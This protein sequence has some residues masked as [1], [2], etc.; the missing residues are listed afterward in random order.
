MKIPHQQIDASLSW[1]WS[2]SGLASCVACLLVALATIG[3]ADHARAD[4]NDGG[5]DPGVASGG[6]ETVGTLPILGGVRI[7][8]P[9]VR[10]WRGDRPAFYL[11]GTAAELG[12][13][14][15]GARGRGFATVEVLDPQSGRVRIAFHGDVTVILDRE[16]TGVL[17]VQTGLA[18]PEGFGPRR[19]TLEWGSSATRTVRLHA[20][21]L[22][23]AVGSMS[24]NGL[25][26]QAPL[27]VRV[28]G[29]GGT[30]HSDAVFATPGTLILRQSY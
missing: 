17:A 11:E 22:P 2:R 21:L 18:V 29:Q 19:A 26:D 7:E 16:L 8:L 23:L 5:G 30:V 9:L 28:S 25:L 20:G 1:G 27:K 4:I 24:A 15:R 12:Y 3:L 6:D 10:G 14:I 13:V